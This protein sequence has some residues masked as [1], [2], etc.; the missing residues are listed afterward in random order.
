MAAHPAPVRTAAETAAPPP[1][2]LGVLDDPSNRRGPFRPGRLA[3]VRERLSGPTLARLFRYMD[4]AAVA[5]V[6]VAGAMVQAPAGPLAQPFGAVLPLIA[7]SLA[8]LWALSSLRAYGFSSRETP[9]R[10]AARIAGACTLAA[11]AGLVAAA[12][13]DP[14][15]MTQVEAF[16]ACIFAALSAVHLWAWAAVRHWRSQGRLTPNVV[17]VGATDNA[18]MLIQ[19]ALDSREVNV[20]GIFDDRSARSPADLH[21][22]PVLG[23]THALLEHKIL[24][25]VDRIVITVTASAQTRVRALIEQLRVLPNAVTL[26]VDVEGQDTRAATLS[27]LADTPLTQVAGINEDERR[28][29]H[30]RVQDLVCGGLGL[31]V[32]APVMAIIAVAIRLDSPGPVM[33]RQRRH[34]FNNEA[35]VVWKFRSMRHEKADP[36]VVSQQVRKDDDRV[37]RVGRFIRRTSLDE[38]P[39]IFNVLSGEMSLVGPRPHPI[40]MIT[41]G[42][43]SQRLVAEYA[44]RHRMKPGITGWAQINGS[45]GPVHNREEVRRRVVLD[46]EYIE[47]QSFWFDLWIMLMTLPCLLGDRDTIR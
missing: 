4:Y 2:A 8:A 17:V 25:F 28:A 27:R 39:Q 32:F 38:L 30:K 43:E 24:P 44:W 1:A 20:L 34:G 18:A 33:F 40:G 10:H 6:T 36:I 29:F 5:G 23:D 21:G 37:T 46:V 22:V 41:A 14:G 19:S 13:A 12:L 31:I 35:I 42:E 9:Q 45:R 16:A 11:I 7:V 47:R 3:S 15:G 26:F